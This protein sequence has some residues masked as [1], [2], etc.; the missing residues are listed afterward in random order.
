MI[1]VQNQAYAAIL[2]DLPTITEGTKTWDKKSFVKAADIRQMLLVF[3]RVANE[4]E[5]KSAPLP[6]TVD[7]GLR[8]PHGLT[9]P[10]HDCRNRRF[11]KRLSKLEI[12]NKEAEVERLLAADRNAVN[13]RFEFVDERQDQAR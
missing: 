4:Q 10:M 12:Q 9:P 13:T 11:R 2:L 1:T 3:A 8:W 6:A 7:Q 5:A